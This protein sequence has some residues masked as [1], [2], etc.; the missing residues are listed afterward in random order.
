MTIQKLNYMA[1]HALYPIG[2]VVHYYGG[3]YVVIANEEEPFTEEVA[4]KFH[5]NVGEKKFRIFPMDMFEYI[6][7]EYSVDSNGDPQLK[8]LD[9]TPVFHEGLS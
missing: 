6:I 9:F 7:A 2:Q 1:E 5:L 8:N 3:N 4:K